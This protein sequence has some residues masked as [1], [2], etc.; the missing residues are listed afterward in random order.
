MNKWPKNG[1]WVIVIDGDL[2]GIYTKKRQAEN[3]LSGINKAL[4]FKG[5]SG[6]PIGVMHTQQY[7]KQF[8]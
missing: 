4:N 8:K 3:A 2:A 1:S 7:R 6:V 5:V